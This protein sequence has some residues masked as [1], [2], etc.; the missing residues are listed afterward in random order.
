ML[1]ADARDDRVDRVLEHVLLLVGE[2]LRR[3]PKH[4]VHSPGVFDGDV[5]HE[6]HRQLAEYLAVLLLFR[7]VPGGG[8]DRADDAEVS[9]RG[10]DAVPEDR[11]DA[12]VGTPTDV[13][14]DD[15]VVEECR[16]SRRRHGPQ[17]GDRLE[18]QEPRLVEERRRCRLNDWWRGDDDGRF[19]RF[20]R[21]SS[22]WR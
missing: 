7:E 2:C 19:P 11:R 21:G 9:L 18:G 15:H 1:G 5:M 17:A 13:G 16:A 6:H 10:I 22:C 20:L 8:P 4:G 12:L 14:A 3:A